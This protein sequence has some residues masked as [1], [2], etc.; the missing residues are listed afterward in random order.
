MSEAEPIERTVVKKDKVRLDDIVTDNFILSL[1]SFA[2][3]ELHATHNYW[4]GKAVAKVNSAIKQYDATRLATL[5]K[6]SQLKENGEI[7]FDERN[8]AIYKSEG[9]RDKFQA[10]LRDLRQQ[11][12]EVLKISE[13]VARKSKA[14]AIHIAGI[15]AI[16]Y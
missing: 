2:D 11:E 12:I 13:E 15:D 14:K 16:L 6:Y 1:S 8:Q 9:D 10:E 5:K 3:S 7:K 4:V